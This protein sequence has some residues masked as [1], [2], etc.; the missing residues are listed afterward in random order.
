MTELTLELVE[1]ARVALAG[2]IRHTPVEASP[3]LSAVLGVP[4]W[5]KLECL[6]ITGSFKV[7]GALFRL[8]QLSTEERSQGVA[9]CSAGN[10]GKAL[11]FAARRLGIKATIYVPSSVDEVKVRGIQAQGANVVRS[12]YPGFD[13]TQAWALQQ[14]GQN[15]QIFISAFDDEWIMAGNG[16]TLAAEVC[17]DLPDAHAFVL[18]VSGGGL[19]AGF[20][21]FVRM[22]LPDVQ[23]IGCQH[24]DSASL[25]LSLAR[26]EA[27][28]SLPPI[29]TLAGG[30]EGG[31]GAKTFGVLRDKIDAV[32]LVS[33][34]EIYQ[35][36]RW[37]LDRHQYLVEPSGAATVAACLSGRVPG[38]QGPAVIVLSGRNVGLA[39]VNRIMNDG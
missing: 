10:H 31:I 20:S 29:D 36:V 27:V 23:I 35:A 4:V 28:T 34:G 39:A 19:A 18:P 21:Y 14:I 32:A 9:T 8:L 30:L 11:A 22:R 33:E 38:L 37:I 25:R 7:R 3:D 17:D 24:R 6:Q 2:Q 5:L 26:G 16:G 15:G 12:A 13:E 1:A